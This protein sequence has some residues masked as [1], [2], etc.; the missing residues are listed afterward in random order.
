M[1]A[2]LV[3]L[4]FVYGDEYASYCLVHFWL[5]SSGTF[6]TRLEPF[7]DWLVVVVMAVSAF[8]AFESHYVYRAFANQTFADRTN[9]VLPR[10]VQI[11]LILL[12]RSRRNDAYNDLMDWYP[13]WVYDH[14][15][16]SANFICFLKVSS[17]IAYELLDF[18]YR[19]GEVVGKFRSTK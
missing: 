5:R 7:A 4:T 19:V 3:I 10:C 6:G 18:L 8:V 11:A 2:A 12:S 9:T 16:R 15:R 17:A 14:G 13:G 1:R